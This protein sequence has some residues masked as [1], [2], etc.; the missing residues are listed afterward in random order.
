[1]FDAGE[2][3]QLAIRIEENGEKFYQKM[4]EKFDEPE[5]KKLFT[6]LAQEEVGHQK[7]Y[8]EILSTFE[9]YEP[10][11]SYPGEYFS[12]L[13]SYADNIIFS[14]KEFEKRMNEIENPYDA[15]E[16]AIGAELNSILYY[17]EVKKMVS[18][19]NHEKIEKI[20]NEERKHF[21]QL[22]EIKKDFNY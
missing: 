15:I 16:F 9:S 12:Y 6:F 1:M 17:Q 2:I 14:Q 8:Q 18:E 5:L 22:S 21:V 10:H 3:F 20:I 13:R 4:S 11:E 7:V 19:K